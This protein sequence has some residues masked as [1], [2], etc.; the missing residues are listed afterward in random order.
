MAKETDR[1]DFLTQR[2]LRFYNRYDAETEMIRQLLEIRLH[3]LALAYTLENR[4]PQ[5]AI[6]V[7]S[8]LKT[9]SSFISK[10]ERQGWPEFYYPT[11]VA[12]DLIGARVICWFLDD[13]YG[14]LEYI[15]SSEQFEV[16]LDSLEDYIETPKDTGYRSIH[17]LA[18]IVYDRVR[19]VNGKRKVV[20]DKMV[21]EIQIRTKLQDAWA[22]LTHEILYKAPSSFGPDY[23][24]LVAEFANRLFSE[25]K[26]A[27]AIRNILQRV[28]KE[29]EHEGFRD[30]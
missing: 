1:K 14:I 30:E 22:E 4:L 5:E 26:S 3:Q 10:L 11:E 20:S 9:F 25:D 13:C 8:R 19:K 29:K 18:D 6:Q 28:P 15:Q 2:A 7:H 12:Q 21:C 16:Q 24:V 27:M 17:L 23:K